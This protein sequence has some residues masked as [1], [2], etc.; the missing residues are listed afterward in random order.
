VNLDATQKRIGVDSFGRCL[1]FESGSF[2]AA[3][4][5]V[6]AFSSIQDNKVS[7]HEGKR[8]A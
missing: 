4:V 2:S 1:G 7:F 5:F 6:R 8:D 3:M